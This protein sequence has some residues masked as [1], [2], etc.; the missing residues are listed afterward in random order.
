MLI[1]H[2]FKS[3]KIIEV[4]AMRI[5]LQLVCN[6]KEVLESIQCYPNT[7]CYP[8][9]EELFDEILKENEEFLKPV[10]YYVM[11]NQHGEG[12]KEFF[13]QMVCC[14][15]TLDKDV[16]IKMSA[17]FAEDDYMKGVLMSSMADAIIFQASTQLYQLIF[18]TVKAQGMM[19][20]K[21]IEPGT[22]GATVIA[23]KWILETLNA[24]ENTG[25]I[26]TSGY[27]LNPTKSMGYF[28]GIGKSIDSTPIDHDCSECDHISC[29][30]RKIYITV[31][32][33][34]EDIILRVKKGGNL[35]ETLRENKIPI[36][37]DCS[38]NHK[39]R[40]CKVRVVSEQ[41]PLSEVENE[42][43][44][45]MEK[46]NGTVLACFH[47]VEKDL[48]IEIKNYKADILTDFDFPMLKKRKYEVKTI[49]GLSKSPQHNES[50]TDLIYQITGQKYHYTL[51]VIRKLSEVM[52]Q[53]SF[54]AIIKDEVEVVQIQEEISPFYGFG[55]DIGTTTVVIALLNLLEEKVISIYKCMNPQKAYGADVISRI[56]FTT[57]HPEGALTKYIH[58]AL[59][60]G[61]RNLLE[62]YQIPKEQVLE[63][64]IAG[65]TTMQYLL[66]GIN[67][68]S[69]TTSPFLTTYLEQIKIPFSE[70]FM[71]SSLSCDVVVMPGL[72]AYIGADILAGMYTTDLEEFAGNYLFIDIGTNGELAIKANN[73]LICVAT[74]AGPAFEGANITCG[75]GCLEGA[76]C[77][78]TDE[79]GQFKLE[80]IGNSTPKGI[81]GSGLVDLMALCLKRGLVDDTGRI[82]E[83]QCIKITTGGDSEI[84]LYQQDVRELQLAKAAIAAGIAVLLHESGCSAENL[85]A[86][87]IAG[88]FGYHLNV[89]NAITIG[90][91]PEELRNK[92]KVIGNS[93]LGG[94]I[95]YLLEKGS[96]ATLKRIKQKCEYIELS[97]NMIFYDYYINEMNF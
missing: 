91:L 25:I 53:K 69:L 22:S 77:G 46:V 27:M 87:F 83:G 37:A 1:H 5:E 96:E 21:R 23:Q 50:A 72:S 84:A 75:M 52:K 71:E 8:I 31:R 18:E 78:V 44:S 32:T 20:T 6:K 74:A 14:I 76:I 49:E 92:T 66:T 24:V 93:S 80:I 30:H 88:G 40:K 19:M 29:K 16:D 11:T 65:N 85:D 79:V 60:K 2:A 61:I 70:L 95:R 63:V 59:I 67:P 48:V 89:E 17:Y 56:Q 42:V 28:Y 68:K 33:N 82:L 43:L 7:A 39:C 94:S 4:K 35:L 45:A 86:L 97:T 58:E 90:L 73:R 26:I 12:I 47:N 3:F 15:V 81:C 10:G 54:V 9:Y 13:D 62:A 36:Q 64:A 55:I 38:G 41:L 51:P 57:E 34:E